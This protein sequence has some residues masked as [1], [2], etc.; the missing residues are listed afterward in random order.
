MHA[1]DTGLID[2][3][4]EMLAAEKGHAQ[5]SLAAYQR[6][7]TAFLDWVDTPATSVTDR[8][9]RDYLAR[10]E[11]EG[12]AASTAARRLSV[13]KHFYLFLFQ[14]AVTSHN[15]ASG[16]EGPL[17][18]RRLPGVLSEAQ[19]DRLLDR[20]E[21]LADQRP[22]HLPPVRLHA[23]VEV[24]YA[25]GLRVSELAGL[26]RRA[27]VDGGDMLFL[28]GKGG[29][30]R[31]VPLSKKARTAL[32]RYSALRDGGPDADSSYLFASRGKEGHLTRQR[33]GQM[34]KDLAVQAGV[35]PSRV[36]PHKLRHAFAT[37]L[38]AGGADLRVVQQ[39]LGHV[40]ISTTQIYTHILD[41]RMKALVEAHHPLAKR[42]GTGRM[43][44]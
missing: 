20:A 43:A 31:M 22:D 23:I 27:L 21:A 41:A 40:D 2:A 29:R 3:F 35:E 5:N 10:L 15:P 25:T 16:I 7:I 6:D 34:L 38:L 9:I 1:S 11:A 14:D 28:V 17:R 30:E 37:H 24:L 32:A 39:I 8:H 44:P 12:L 18:G 19:V 33:I 26:P 42:S 4:L 13:I 36:S